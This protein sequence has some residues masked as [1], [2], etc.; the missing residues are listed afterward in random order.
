MAI[1]IFCPRRADSREHLWAEWIGK[2]LARNQ[3]RLRRKTQNGVFHQWQSSTLNVKARVVCT[4]CNTTWMSDLESE[5][6]L[7]LR[8]MILHNAA[9][10]ILPRGIA[11]LAAYAFMKAVIASHMKSD[12]APFFSRTACARFAATLE[13]PPGVQV[14]TAA[15]RSGVFL[16]GTFKTLYGKSHGDSVPNF[17]THVC[18]LAVRYV[19]LQTVAGRFTKHSW[20]PFNL[21][22]DVKWDNFSIPLWPSDGTPITWPPYQHLSDDTIEA[23]CNRWGVFDFPTWMTRLPR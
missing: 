2:V 5:V 23:F 8:D 16:D 22:Q 3:Y 4:Q 20:L 17:E 15:M 13:I 7:I 1:C 19:V 6:R 21:A 14:W 12:R 11:S 18:T 10:S 9:V